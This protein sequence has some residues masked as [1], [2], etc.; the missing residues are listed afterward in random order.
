MTAKN[1]AIYVRISQDRSGA[2]L[3]V[4]RQEA[5]CRELADRLGWTVADMYCDNDISAYS[6]RRRP[7]YESMLADVEAG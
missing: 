4:E 1:A 3:G 5:E 6:G 2:G 7:D